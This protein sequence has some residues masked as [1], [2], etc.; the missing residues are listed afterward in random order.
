MLELFT[1]DTPK[2]LHRNQKKELEKTAT[3]IENKLAELQELKQNTQE[4]M[5]ENQKSG[6]EV[7]AWGHI[8]E[9]KFEEIAQVKEELK[10]AIIWIKHEGIETNRSEEFEKGETKLRKRIDEKLII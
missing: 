9:T 7:K 6:E 10:Q 1:N 2:V 4:K 3:L 5:L 8:T